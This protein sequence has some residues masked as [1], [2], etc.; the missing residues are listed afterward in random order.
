[1]FLPITRMTYQHNMTFVTVH[2]VAY[3]QTI[4]R[5]TLRAMIIMNM[6]NELY[7]SQ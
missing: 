2:S 4:S 5:N 1:L 7:P 3:G 6:L